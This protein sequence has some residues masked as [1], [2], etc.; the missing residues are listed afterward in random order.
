MPEQKI[1]SL[2]WWNEREKGGGPQVTAVSGQEYEVTFWWR[3][4]AGTASA[5]RKVW[6]F[7]TGVTDHHQA[8]LPQSLTRLEGTDAW[9]W[10]VRLPADWRGSYCFIPTSRDDDFAG[11]TPGADQVTRRALRDGWRRLLPHAISDP[12]NP[13]SWR[14]GRGHGVSALSLPKAP[15]Q[16]GWDAPETAFTPAT[17]EQW[18]SRRLGNSR[19]IWIFA[20]GEAASRPLAVLLDGQFWAQDMPVWQPLQTL[21]NSGQLPAAV[22]LFIDVIDNDHRSRELPCNPEFWQAVSEELLPM[23]QDIAPFS[24]APETTVVAGQSFGGLSALYAALGWPQH[25]GCALSQSGS[26]WWP[27]REHG[28]DGGWLVEQIAQ[29]ALAPINTRIWLGAGAREP[30]IMRANVELRRVLS[31]RYPQVPVA[32]RPNEGGH[33]ALCWR[34]GLT[35][36]LIELWGARPR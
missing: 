36:G 25:Y 5:I 29:G 20:T 13:Q 6:I 11:V 32:W 9:R 26:Y 2:A 17:C 33:D 15:L 35:T 8:S 34:G 12:L 1:G 14:G 4:P 28:G 18:H 30:L 19:R 10:T 31:E 23:V 24:P 7:I 27:S 21:T 22:Y 16:P 3:D